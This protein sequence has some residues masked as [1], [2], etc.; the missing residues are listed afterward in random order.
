M[1]YGSL[2]LRP[3]LEYSQPIRLLGALRPE[4]NKG[5][6]S[7]SM[8]SSSVWEE[9]KALRKDTSKKLKHMEEEVMKQQSKLSPKNGLRAPHQR[10]QASS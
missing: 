10:H 9:K 5:Q 6:G 2:K 3:S 7:R 1:R 8:A 4:V